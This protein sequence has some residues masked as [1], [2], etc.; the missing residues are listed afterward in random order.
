MKAGTRE[1]AR[2]AVFPACRDGRTRGKDLA[3][4]GVDPR[5]TSLLKKRACPFSVEVRKLNAGFHQLEH[6]T[7][8]ARDA[9]FLIAFDRV[10]GT[11]DRL[12]KLLLDGLNVCPFQIG[13]VT[14]RPREALTELLGLPRFCGR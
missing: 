1:I 9:P 13:E 12:T 3:Q 6:H 14:N 10:P 8:V 7:V 5:V 11:T 2:L 4:R